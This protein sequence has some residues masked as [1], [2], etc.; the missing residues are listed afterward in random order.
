MKSLL[1]S[2]L[3]CSAIVV[4]F[5]NSVQAQ[6]VNPTASVDTVAAGPNAGTIAVTSSWANCTGIDSVVI[7]VHSET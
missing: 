7:I 2:A 5:P 3:L 1:C 4:I 6:P